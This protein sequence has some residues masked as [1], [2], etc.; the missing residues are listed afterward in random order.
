MK[1]R[2]TTKGLLCAAAALLLAAGSANASVNTMQLLFTNLVGRATL[3]NLF[4]VHRWHE[5]LR[6]EILGQ[7]IHDRCTTQL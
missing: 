4:R 7:R 6:S 1:K 2:L 5:W 3:T